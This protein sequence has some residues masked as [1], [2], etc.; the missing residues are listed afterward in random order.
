MRTTAE[1]LGTLIGFDTVSERSNLA[2]IAW[3]ED[4]LR[5]HGFDCHRVG[6]ASGEKAGLFAQVGPC[7]DGGLLLSA[8]CDVVP[9]E[10]QAWSRD[11]FR[12][13]REGGR[14][15]GRGTTDM[16]G[17]LACALNAAA[18]A[19]AGA[20]ERPLKLAVSYDEEIGCVGIRDMIG[21][22]RPAI[23]LAGACVVGEPTSM[24][25]AVGHKGKLFARATCHGTPGHTA[26]APEF[27]N[28]LHLATDLV[29][30]LRALQAR[31]AREG[32]A[33]PAYSIPY[34]TVHVASVHG[35]VAAN[36]VPEHASVDF[37]IRHLPQVDPQSILDEVRG[38]I[39]TIC[40][41]CADRFPRARIDLDILKAYP[42]LETDADHP[43]V[44]SVLECTPAR[45][46]TKVAY[47]T[48]AGYFSALGIPT[49]VCGPGDMDQGHKPDEFIEIAQLDACDAMLDAL[50]ARVCRHGASM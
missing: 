37:E 19:A 2:I 16:K 41:A 33:D 12:M 14:L 23:G 39:G 38:A 27:L 8:H 1:I 26:M 9:V 48:E 25:V 24:R 11:P 4:F 5:A 21:H 44:R 15:Y 13:S 45:E 32:P 36:I 22:M 29:A 40:A 42:G 47:G 35:G 43:F 7:G 34:S 20:L 17:F 10:G 18:R 6:D 28:A 49:V 31:L 3:I 46:I 30:S 50:I